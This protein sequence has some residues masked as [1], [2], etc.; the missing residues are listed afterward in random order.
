MTKKEKQNSGFGELTS[1]AGAV[2]GPKK[3]AAVALLLLIPV[4]F[5]VMLPSLIFG[6]LTRRDAGCRAAGP[7]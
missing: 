3:A 6:G 7:Q 1:A 2:T 5:I 4:L